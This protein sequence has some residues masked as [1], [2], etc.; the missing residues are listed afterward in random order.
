MPNLSCRRKLDWSKTLQ[1]FRCARSK[2][3]ISVVPGFSA[4]VHIEK[5]ALA[6][7]SQFVADQFLKSFPLPYH[8]YPP[9]LYHN[10]CRP[11]ARVVVGS[12]C[13][14]VSTRIQDGQKLTFGNLGQFA[15]TRKKISGLANRPHDIEGLRR[16]VPPDDWHNFVIGLIQ[17][18]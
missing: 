6:R 2:S 18:R 10:L 7:G 16:T 15:I 17:R 3:V 14:A 4:W 12:Q 1:P 8:P 9:A 11:R 5:R 13:H